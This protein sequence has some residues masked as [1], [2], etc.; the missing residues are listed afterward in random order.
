MCFR[1]AVIRV[2]SRAIPLRSDRLLLTGET[3]FVLWMVE[4]VVI[5][6]MVT[7]SAKV[8]QFS[9]AG[10]CEHASFDACLEA[11]SHNQLPHACN[12]SFDGIIALMIGVGPITLS[13]SPITCT[14]SSVASLTPCLRCSKRCLMA[15]SGTATRGAL[16]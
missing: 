1:K 2:A 5:D 13:C 10:V 16:G 14:S 8:M 11:V 4:F 6:A 12:F 15:V 3:I 7:E 9:S